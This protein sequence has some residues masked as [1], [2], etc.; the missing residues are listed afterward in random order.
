MND[1]VNPGFYA[2]IKFL[3]RSL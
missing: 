2:K 3:L 1:L